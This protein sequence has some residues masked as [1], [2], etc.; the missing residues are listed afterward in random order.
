MLL[1]KDAL[2][3]GEEEQANPTPELK[4]YAP[5]VLIFSSGDMTPFELSIRRVTD[6]LAVALKGDLL[7]NIEFIEDEDTQR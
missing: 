4:N 7:G 1:D 2:G 5:H 3:L 6:Q